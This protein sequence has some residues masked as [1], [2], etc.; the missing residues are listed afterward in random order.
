VWRKEEE[1]SE[2]EAAIY[3]GD[4]GHVQKINMLAFWS[5]KVGFLYG[6][7]VNIPAQW[8]VETSIPHVKR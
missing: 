1:L 6:F 5:V 7:L 3:I 4:K 8:R 2:D